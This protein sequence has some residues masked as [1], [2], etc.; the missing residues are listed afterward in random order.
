LPLPCSAFH[1]TWLVLAAAERWQQCFAPTSAMA[2]WSSESD[3]EEHPRT[4]IFVDVDGV[5]NVGVRDQDAAPL[6]F[7]HS[8]RDFALKQVGRRVARKADQ[9]TIERLLSVA[10]RQVSPDSDTTF[11]D[12]TCDRASHIADI[13]AGHLASLIDKAGDNCSVVLSSNWRKP[14]R[15]SNVLRLEQI[16]SS[17]LGRPFV[18]DA[19][20]APMLERNAADRLVCLGDY[21]E[22]VSEELDDQE[23]LRA[24]VL[25]DFFISPLDGW[26]IADCKIDSVEAA[27]KYLRM[28]AGRPV[29]VKLVHTYDEWL[30]E[31]GLRVQVGTGL[32]QHHFDAA[33]KFLS[34]GPA[35]GVSALAVPP[36]LASLPLVFD[37]KPWKQVLAAESEFMCGHAMLRN[38]TVSASHALIG[39]PWADFLHTSW[40][41]LSMYL[42]CAA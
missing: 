10:Q 34:E 40:P 9:M 42:P 16:M 12:L 32:L 3:A 6:L 36:Q 8:N 5:L 4:I 11:S 14:T 1:Y 25:E 31:S 21:L 33:L 26:T 28:R 20:T 22:K 19:K 15:A 29:D 39:N 35:G 13:Y 38:S 23:P 17:H 30:T 18:F 24:L 7:D 2:P 27:E 41:W 37:A